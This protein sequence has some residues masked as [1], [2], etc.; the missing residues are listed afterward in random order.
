MPRPHSQLQMTQNPASCDSPFPSKPKARS[1]VT[2]PSPHSSPTSPSP[3]PQSPFPA[4]QTAERTLYPPD[5]FTN[6]YSPASPGSATS[7]SRN[8]SI[9][10]KHPIQMPSPTYSQSSRAEQGILSRDV[11]SRSGIMYSDQYKD[12]GGSVG[13]A[14]HM[15][16][17]YIY[18]RQEDVDVDEDKMSDHAVWLLVS[19]NC[20]SS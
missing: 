16:P 14:V 5:P 7:Y 9:T 12:R 2:A 20:P 15:S 8:P 3:T 11:N 6:E 17:E 19:I 18:Q 13:S 10:E 1:S 4:L